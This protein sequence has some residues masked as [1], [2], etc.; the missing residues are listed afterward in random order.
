M[1]LLSTLKSLTSEF[2]IASLN[3]SSGTTPELL[4]KTFGHYC[5]YIKTTQGTVL[6]PTVPGKWL[7]VFCDEV[8]L[9]TP[10]KY[11]TQRVIM[12]MR[13]ITEHGFFWRMSAQ[14]AWEKV[15]LERIQFAGACNPPTDAGR[16]PMSDR[17]LRHAPILF[18]DFPGAESL[19][20]IYG[21]F[22]RA[23]L[24]TMPTV[25][26]DADRVTNV[27]VDFYSAFQK[28]FTVDM[29]PHYIYSPRELSR[30]KLAINEA[31]K[32]FPDVDQV[33][34]ARLL[35]HE[36]HRIFSDRLVEGAHAKW[37]WD[38]LN[39]IILRHF[40]QLTP[41]DLQGPILFSYFNSNHYSECPVADLRALIEGKF[42]VFHEEELNVQLVLFD[43]CLDHILRI[44]RVLRQPLGHLLLVGAS[45]AGKTVLPRFVSWLNGL[46]VFQIKAG[47]NYDV[48]AFEADLR[49]VMKRCGVKEEKVTFI[50]DESNVLGPAFL[51]RMNA[52]LAA[53]EVPGLFEGDEYNA[54]ISE[55]KQAWGGEQIDEPEVFAKFTKQV[56]RNL[57]IVFTMNPANP[58]FSNRQATSP[59][60][61]NRCVI[62]WFGDWPESA[63][64][65]VAS[66]FLKNIELNADMFEQG[67]NMTEDERRSE[68]A[69]VI[70]TCH[71]NVA[72]I[73]FW[74]SSNGR[75]H[76][77]VTP[78]DYLD[79]LRH[80]LAFSAEKKDEVTE[81]AK[82]LT[83]GLTKLS[84]TNSQVAE[85][86]VQCLLQL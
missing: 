41:Q 26:D 64:L 13:Q 54:L 58:E 39:E 51:E 78:R 25:A 74:L 24:R 15:R 7:I 59:A 4:L 32:K 44:D 65:H 80:F 49:T 18:V 20:Q 38:C 71:Q 57:H 9:P 83:T 21:T 12:F 86:Q 2:E 81:T 6:R 63:M 3:F 85:L 67:H 17:F 14:G 68:L 28:E 52:L 75:K 5:E 79:F 73:N 30:W 47:R 72:E 19:R 40:S 56:Q 53:G 11:H 76:N 55:C 62:D 45:G 34:L 46:S 82:H 37:S 48:L 70:V 60:L 31:F 36:A 50:F 61:F 10:D 35:C 42:R 23:M 66:D 8:N 69:S 16:H 33:T 27:M 84:E 22:N 77:Y 43:A 1:T 29:Q